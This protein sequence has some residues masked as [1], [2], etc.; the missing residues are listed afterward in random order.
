MATIFKALGVLIVALA[1]VYG[2]YSW[3][4]WRDAEASIKSLEVELDSLRVEAS[5]L[6]VTMAE[7][8]SIARVKMDST[9]AE[10][11]KADST[12]RAES[13]KYA[14][15][16]E[17][18][19]GMVSDTANAIIDSMTVAH[20]TALTNKDIIIAGL[21]TDIRLLQGRIL[22][23]DTLIV[24]YEKQITKLENQVGKLTTTSRKSILE[25]STDV[26]EKGLAI[27]GLVRLI[28]S[29]ASG[30]GVI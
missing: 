9:A 17:Q 14:S 5:E 27:Y 25:F 10:R 13:N 4:S 21:K 16:R 22:D 30:E 20:E 29:L 24:N 1:L 2:V 26:A 18:V 12:A 23:R 6:R 3:V 11:A 15:L 8:D 7:R 28:D 19:R